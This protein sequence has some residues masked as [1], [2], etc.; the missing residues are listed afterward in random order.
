MS[1]QNKDVYRWRKR[2]GLVFGVYTI[3][4]LLAH[5]TFLLINREYIPIVGPLNPEPIFIV[6]SFT[7]LGVLLTNRRPDHRIGWLFLLVG[8]LRQ[9]AFVDD[10]ALILLAQGAEPSFWLLL[11][12][13][14]SNWVAGLTYT[15]LALII[16][17]FPTGHLP[18]PRWKPALWVFGFQLTLTLGIILFLSIDMYRFLASEPVSGGDL[19]E[20][21]TSF[22]GSTLIR[23]V[24]ELPL[25]NPLF[26]LGGLIFLVLGFTALWSQITQFRQGDTIVKQ[27]IKWVI[28]A[29]TLWVVVFILVLVFLPT[30]DPQLTRFLPFVFLVVLLVPIAIA[31]AILRYRL[32]DIDIIIRRTLVYGILTAV[33]ILLYFGTVALLQTLLSATTRQE[34]PAVIVISTLVIAALFNPLRDRIQGFINRRFYRREYNSDKIL[35][36]FSVTVRDEVDVDSLAQEILVVADTTMQPEMLSLWLKT[37]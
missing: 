34:S 5:T 17:I 6:A 12:V 27:Q 14:L 24:R 29:V 25:L 10:I 28:F 31:L 20:K 22:S 7:F 26:I 19:L 23:H 15:L 1:T 36:D 3:G 9:I 21:G 16:V 32:Y 18:S 11:G 37:D 30:L 8:L 4:V 2:F 13:N 33:L 35:Q